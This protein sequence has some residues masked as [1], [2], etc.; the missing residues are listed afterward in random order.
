MGIYLLYKNRDVKFHIS[1]LV[2]YYTFTLSIYEPLVVSIRMVSP[3]LT[4]NGTLITAPESIVAGFVTLDEA[5]SPLKPGS[6]CATTKLICWAI[7]IARTISPSN[8]TW[9]SSFSLKNQTNH[10]YVFV[11]QI[12]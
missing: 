3:S 5:V 9:T 10:A 2:L 11:H 7:S 8:E 12:F 6:V 4:N 1:T